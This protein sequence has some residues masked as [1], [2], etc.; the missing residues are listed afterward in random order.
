MGRPTN[1]KLLCLLLRRV[2]QSGCGHFATHDDE[3]QALQ[4]NIEM[5]GHVCWLVGISFQQTFSNRHD[6][7]V[8]PR[9][10]GVADML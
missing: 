3:M 5:A 2:S 6:G 9:A 4:A 10:V 1:L 8:E 7:Y